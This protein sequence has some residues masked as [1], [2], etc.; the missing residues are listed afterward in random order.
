MSLA[1]VVF[2]R[3][4]GSGREP[5]FAL[6][7]GPG[8]PATSLASYFAVVL[9]AARREHDVVL[10]DQRG[11]AG[12]HRLDC[13]VA[14]RTFVVPVDP[15]RCAGRLGQ[16]ADLRLYGTD[17]FVRDLDRVRES[18][19]YE[20]ISMFASSYGTRA[21]FVYARRNPSR[22]RSLILLSAAPFGSSIIQTAA[23][24]GR[25]S[26]DLIVG[27]C[28]ADAECSSRYPSLGT[29]AA[30]ARDRLTEP[31]HLLGLQFLQYSSATWRSIPYLLTEVAAGNL[32]PFERSV[33]EFRQRLIGQLSVG[34]HLTVMCSEDLLPAGAGGDSV[35]VREYDK[36]CAS[37]PRH[38]PPEVDTV[39]A[40]V[41]ALVIVGEWDPVTPPGRARQVAAQFSRAQL[42]VVPRT[43]H[44]MPGME[45]CI[46]SMAAGFLEKRSADPACAVRPA[47]PSR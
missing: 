15:E 38:P 22:V 20:Q 45:E 36:A 2:P 42:V 1:V 14:P 19:G 23:S 40:V 47:A 8:Q 18:L 34:L 31:Y 3:L 29:D 37:W 11:T 27:A 4:G 7:G 39:A 30:K 35:V 28:L 13:V 25:R 16:R 44:L 21:A 9:K 32:A 17:D 6:A 12:T 33:A 5:V 46:G 41:P 26:L 43:G 10:V 24:D